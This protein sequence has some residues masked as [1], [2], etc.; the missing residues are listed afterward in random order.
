MPSNKSPGPDGYTCE[1]FKA[2]SSI[3]GDDF[4]AS[5]KYF[6]EKGFLPKGLN[7]TILT[8]V[9]KKEEASVMKNY[10]PI[11]SLAAM[12]YI[13]LYPKFSPTA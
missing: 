3:L 9:P 12:C 4:V 2:S 10:R 6:F 11:L 7:S 5:I 13:R 8:L 1:F